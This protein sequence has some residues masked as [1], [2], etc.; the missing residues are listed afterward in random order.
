MSEKKRALVWLVHGSRDSSWQGPF[1][2]LK[3]E[4]GREV[5]GVR[6]ALASLQ[7][8]SPDLE[9]AVSE[10]VSEGIAEIIIVPGFI[11]SRGH[12]LRDLPKLEA[13]IKNKFPKVIITMT[14]AI[15]E[16]TEVK[17]AFKRCMIRL[18]G[19]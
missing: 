9:K 16:Q 8:G 18:A 11:G 4:L 17:E 2:E 14:E 5:P 3:E 6:F 10:L 1:R 12:V 19:Q 15:G 13:K 7:F